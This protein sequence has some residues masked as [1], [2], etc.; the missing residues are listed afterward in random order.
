MTNKQYSKPQVIKL[1]DVIKT[2]LAYNVGASR[3]FL[4]NRRRIFF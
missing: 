4:F 2:T 3:E 1:G